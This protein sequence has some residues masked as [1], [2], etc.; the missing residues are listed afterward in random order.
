M[1]KKLLQ[2]SGLILVPILCTACQVMPEEEELRTAPLVR[3]YEVEEYEQAAVM[4]G[5]MILNRTV[6]CKYVTLAAKQEELGFSIGG[7]YIDQIYVSE[8]QQVQAG[9]LLAELKNEELMEQISDKEYELKVLNIK[10][11][12]VLENRNLELARQDALIAEADSRLISLMEQIQAC[13]KQIAA[14]Q[15]EQN[16]KD[17]TEEDIAEPEETGGEDQTEEDIAEPGKNDGENRKKEAFA[18]SGTETVETAVELQ[19]E[20]SRSEQQKAALT[21]QAEAAE[22]Q[23]RSLQKQRESVAKSYEKQLRDVE[24]TLYI[25]EL[26]LEELKEELKQRQIYAGIDG[27]VTYARKTT[28]GECSV[29]NRKIVTITDLDTNVFTVSGE[30]TAYFTIGMQVSIM[31]GKKEYIAEVV[32]GSVFGSAEP[33]EDGESVAYLRLTQPDPTLEAGKK[34]SIEITVDQR[35]N[36][37]YVDKRAVKTSNGEAFVYMLDENG[38]RIMQKVVTGLKA[39]DYVEII[40]GLEA[41]ERVI[42]E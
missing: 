25:E 26:R 1:R 17:Q 9:E 2:W 31:C 3:S 39:G 21:E 22:E 4:Q 5:D 18:E 27:T 29:K 32:D 37:L 35:E 23:K 8:G 12:N 33:E 19:D 10:K 40:G 42:I 28:D 11:S 16:R 14:E 20:I 41:G 30:D 36:V 38:L 34:G 7:E 15:E 13:D 24:D 6:S